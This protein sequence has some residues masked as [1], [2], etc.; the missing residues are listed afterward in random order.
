MI[1]LTTFAALLAVALAGS[2][3]GSAWAEEAP[4]YGSPAPAGQMP[5]P[6]RS[7][8]PAGYVPARPGGYAQ[9]RQQAP[10]WP[11]PQQFYGQFPPP[12]PPGGQYRALPAPPAMAR[13]NPLSA[14]LKQTQAQ[15]AA[16]SSELDKAHGL[17]E[18]L[19]GKLQDSL[20]IE[21]SVSDKLAYSTRE[22]Q[23][24]RVRMTEL[25][26]AQSSAN[27]TLEQQRQLIENY[28]AQ[29]GQLTAERDRLHGELGRRD[30][31]LAA[32]QSELQAATQALEQA[33]AMASGAAYALGVVRAQVGAQRDAL[34][35]LEAE[36]ERMEVRPQGD[37]PG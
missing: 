19:H 11:M 9:P 8:V 6:A 5:A 22:Q 10:R 23:A 18:A 1:K 28:Q 24:L 29:N 3:P 2:L 20:A 36:L 37:P 31:Q 25:V 27:A 14:E 26:D 21:A 16:K 15:L 7:G 33:R 13:E 12:Y 17:L 32:L 34:S 4:A 35:Q 30:E